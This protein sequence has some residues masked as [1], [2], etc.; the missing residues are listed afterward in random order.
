MGYLQQA[1]NKLQGLMLINMSEVDSDNAAGK[2]GWH[3]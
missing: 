3:V 2:F 1:F